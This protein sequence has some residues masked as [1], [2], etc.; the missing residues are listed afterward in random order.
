MLF[1]FQLEICLNVTL[2]RQDAV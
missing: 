1:L 2:S